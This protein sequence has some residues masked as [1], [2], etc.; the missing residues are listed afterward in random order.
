MGWG[1]R[2]HADPDTSRKEREESCT[3][4]PAAWAPAEGAVPYG[5]GS[6]SWARKAAGVPVQDSWDT[7]VLF[8]ALKVWTSGWSQRRKESRGE[9]GVEAPGRWVSDLQ[10]ILGESFHPCAL[11]PLQILTY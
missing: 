10:G 7:W 11:P 9:A 8:P 1:A 2:G 5:R 4:P 3:S 6:V